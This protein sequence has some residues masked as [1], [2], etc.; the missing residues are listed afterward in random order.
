[1]QKQ[2]R[3]LLFNDRQNP[4][5]KDLLLSPIPKTSLHFAKTNSTSSLQRSAKTLNLHQTLKKQS[6]TRIQPE[7]R[8]RNRLPSVKASQ[9]KT[10]SIHLK[11]AKLMQISSKAKLMQGTLSPMMQGS[12][13]NVTL[14]IP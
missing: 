14:L 13:K 4:H 1:L 9:K 6:Q 10:N 11:L 3:P 7:I 12:Q 2:T 5:D 8:K